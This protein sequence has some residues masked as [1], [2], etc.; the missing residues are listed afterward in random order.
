ME[1]VSVTREI[2]T[3]WTLRE[4]SRH[5]ETHEPPPPGNPWGPGRVCHAPASSRVR[6][7]TAQPQ[8]AGHVSPARGMCTL[9]QPRLSEYL[10]VAESG[11]SGTQLRGFDHELTLASVH[12]D[13]PNHRPSDRRR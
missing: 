1:E 10:G 5:W 2:R 6:L 13:A 4:I 12:A 9:D 7:V 3:S 8:F 11:R